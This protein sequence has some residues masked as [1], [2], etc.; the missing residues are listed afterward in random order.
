MGGEDLSTKAM[1]D[2]TFYAKKLD[3]LSFYLPPAGDV[4]EKTKAWQKTLRN[5]LFDMKM[6]G[7][8]SEK[9]DKATA[10]VRKLRKQNRR[11]YSENARLNKE[12]D[13]VNPYWKYTPGLP[14]QVIDLSELVSPEF[15][16]VKIKGN[17]YKVDAVASEL[18]DEPGCKRRMSFYLTPLARDSTGRWPRLA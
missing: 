13:S 5:M 10:R 14:E 6:Y 8:I 18:L 3:E 7:V 16:R 4:F 15:P 1:R 11:L 17:Y 12:L 9:S 2:A